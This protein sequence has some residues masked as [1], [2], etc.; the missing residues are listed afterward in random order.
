MIRDAHRD[1]WLDALNW[2]GKVVSEHGRAAKL[3]KFV[4]ALERLTVTKETGTADVTEV[5]TKRTVVL[6]SAY[7]T[8][9]TNLLEDAREIYRWP[10]SSFGTHSSG[11]WS[12]T[13]S[14][15]ETVTAGRETWRDGF[16]T[17]SRPSRRSHLWRARERAAN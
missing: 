9:R 15:R 10:M 4:A 6:A 1:R 17:E 11:G 3:V 13:T 16:G 7:E 12:G 14:S 5:V 8:K 2:Y